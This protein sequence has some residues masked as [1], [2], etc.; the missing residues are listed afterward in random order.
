[1]LLSCFLST[2]FCVFAHFGTASL[3]LVFTLGCGRLQAAVQRAVQAVSDSLQKLEDAESRIAT[4]DRALEEQ[5]DALNR[6][7]PFLH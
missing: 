3:L 4:G 6:S 5:A 7:G 1:V 2:E